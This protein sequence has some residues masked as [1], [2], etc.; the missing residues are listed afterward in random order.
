MLAYTILM[1]RPLSTRS[2][3]LRIILQQA[4]EKQRVICLPD[5]V[6]CVCPPDPSGESKSDP[7]ESGCDG[8]PRGPD[9]DCKPLVGPGLKKSL[10][11]PDYIP[12]SPRTGPGLFMPTT[13]LKFNEPDFTGIGENHY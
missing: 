8:D 6:V 11:F 5:P 9:H 7:P 4:A 10:Q 3:S 2:R 1:P 12:S 13:S